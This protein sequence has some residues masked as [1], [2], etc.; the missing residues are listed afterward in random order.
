MD[1]VLVRCWICNDLALAACD[2]CGLPICMKQSSCRKLVEGL[3]PGWACTACYAVIMSR[4]L[5]EPFE[6]LGPTPPSA[7][8]ESRHD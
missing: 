2:Y 5:L 6:G 4:G 8:W 3:D 1:E 7:G